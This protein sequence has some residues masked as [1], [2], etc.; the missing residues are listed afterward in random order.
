MSG[1]G[2]TSNEPNRQ[3]DVTG[4]F[5]KGKG[6]IISNEFFRTN[7]PN[8]AVHVSFVTDLNGQTTKANYPLGKPTTGNEITDTNALTFG[9]HRITDPKG[10]LTGFGPLERVAAITTI[11][12]NS[13]GVAEYPHVAALEVGTPSTGAEYPSPQA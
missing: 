2:T 6:G 11:N 10:I 7:N 5:N 1:D 9:S 4:D 12:I 13:N 8:A 3:L